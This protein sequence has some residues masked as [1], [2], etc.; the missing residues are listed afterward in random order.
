MSEP[1]IKDNDA[2][3]KMMKTDRLISVL[4]VAK[5]LRFYF[6]SFFA[7]FCGYSTVFFQV[8]SILSLL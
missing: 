2:D 3:K 5:H 6:Y 1:L 4:S 7:P 8:F